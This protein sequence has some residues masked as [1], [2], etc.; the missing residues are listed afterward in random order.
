ML[1]LNFASLGLIVTCH[2]LTRSNEILKS[3]IAFIKEDGHPNPI[4]QIVHC[5]SSSK[6]TSIKVFSKKS[7]VPAIS[8]T[9]KKWSLFPNKGQPENTIYAKGQILT[10]MIERH[11]FFMD[12]C[13]MGMEMRKVNLSKRKK[14]R[15][16]RLESSRQGKTIK[17]FYAQ[18][19]ELLTRKTDAEK[20]I[21]LYGKDPF[22]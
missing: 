20:R 22:K 9:E 15:K 1:D 2:F 13:Y 14:V 19:L 16:K 10:N 4:G 21:K 6:S 17:R 8:P 5:F 11:K 3:Q 7:Q 12:L 18:F